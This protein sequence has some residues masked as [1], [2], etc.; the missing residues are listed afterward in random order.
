MPELA[1]FYN[2]NRELLELSDL[3]CEFET[4]NRV[5]REDVLLANG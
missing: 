2:A 3:F 1:V 4:L 5:K